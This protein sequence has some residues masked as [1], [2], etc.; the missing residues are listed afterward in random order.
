M[1][2]KK[3]VAVDCYCPA[4]PCIEIVDEERCSSACGEFSCLYVC[5]AG[6]FEE[7]DGEVVFDRS[8]ICLECGAC[9]LVCKNIK[10]DYPEGGRGIVHKFG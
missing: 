6:L 9:R 1:N 3:R 2:L 10:F 5:P 7:R 8:G 4:R